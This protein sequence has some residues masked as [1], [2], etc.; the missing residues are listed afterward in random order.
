MRG[1]GILFREGERFVFCELL[2][3]DFGVFVEAAVD[4]FEIVIDSIV[5]CLGL[6]VLCIYAVCCMFWVC[7]DNIS[8]ID[9]ERSV[10]EPLTT[11]NGLSCGL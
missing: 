11:H 3:E 10:I 5:L 6:L 8:I 9:I 7:P 4:V 2:V 1:Q